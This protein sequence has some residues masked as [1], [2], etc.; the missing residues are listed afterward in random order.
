MARSHK[1]TCIDCRLRRLPPGMTRG[2]CGD[3][4]RWRKLLDKLFS[5][6]LA[7]HHRENTVEEERT[8]RVI[9]HRRKTR[10]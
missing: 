2:M 1:G 8:K 6:W 7:D 3:C 9:I 5:G 10:Y 4:K